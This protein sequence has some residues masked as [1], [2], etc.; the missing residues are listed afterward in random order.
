MARCSNSQCDSNS[1]NSRNCSTKASTGIGGRE[2]GVR[3]FGVR[4][5]DRSF[6][7]KSA[8]M[9]NI[10]SNCS[11][12]AAA[13]SPE[14]YHSDDPAHG[15]AADAAF[16]RAQRKR[17]TPWTE[18]EH[19]KF[20]QGLQ[21]L[22]KGDWRGI[23]RNYVPSRTP[24]QVASHAQ[25]YFIRQ[26][27]TA[28]RK[29]RSSLF[30]MAPEME[31][32]S[33]SSP[34]KCSSQ[35]LVMNT[36]NEKHTVSSSHMMA[37]IDNSLPSLALTLKPAFMPLPFQLWPPNASSDY[38]GEAGNGMSIPLMLMSSPVAQKEPVKEM[39]G[40]SGISLG[41]TGTFTVEPSPLSLRLPGD[42]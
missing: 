29:K 20:L 13:E 36:D 39:V 22:G 38:D 28:R 25:K 37:G 19:R 4:L 34:E 7:K 3:L 27:N 41:G 33:S 26:S 35:S 15:S 18:E 31:A 21:K 5:T 14:G 11:A 1:P 12:A 10:I 24:T 2:G 16:L 32:F 6:I 23:S 8:S 9:G 17:G 30:D 40:I 42:P